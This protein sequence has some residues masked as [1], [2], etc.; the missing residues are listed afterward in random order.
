MHLNYRHERDTNLLTTDTKNQKLLQLPEK[1]HKRDGINKMNELIYTT[2]KDYNN[3][4]IC[5]L[6]YVLNFV[7]LHQKYILWIKKLTS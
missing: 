6:R 2:N 1:T 3:E 5:R 7:M 4:L